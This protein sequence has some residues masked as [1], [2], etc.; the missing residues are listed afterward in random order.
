MFNTLKLRWKIL[1]SMVGLAVISLAIT[2]FIFSGLSERQLERAE[3]LQIEQT[4]NFAAKTIEFKQMELGGSTEMLGRNLDLLSAIHH[5]TLTGEIEELESV[6]ADIQDI[7]NFDQIQFID[8]AGNVLRRVLGTNQDIPSTSGKEHPA[9]QAGLNGEIESVV[10]MFDDRLA[11]AT[12]VPVQ[13]MQ[14]KQVGVLVVI[15]FLD[16][17]FAFDIKS[18]SGAE[19]AFY[20]PGSIVAASNAALDQLPLQEILQAGRGPPG[21]MNS[22]C[23][24]FSTSAA[25][26]TGSRTSAS[27]TETRLRPLAEP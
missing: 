23:A 1:F 27:T 26:V 2:L 9:I 7:F 24:R 10:T 4:S 21:N 6:I 15:D 22:P 18:M 25:S 8:P 12:V 3:K 17:W 14:Q 16:T 20:K 11:I 5:H 19:I 13:D